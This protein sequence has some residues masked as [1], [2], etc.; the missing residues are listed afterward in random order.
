MLAVA[1]I[2]ILFVVKWPEVSRLFLILLFLAQA[3]AAIT[4]RALIRAYLYSARR[5]GRNMR[6]VLVSE[7]TR[8]LRRSRR[9]S[10]TTPSWAYGS[11][12]SSATKHASWLLAGPTSAHRRLPEVLHEFVI[13]EVIIGLPLAEW[14][15]IDAVLALCEQEGKIV[16]LRIPTPA[17]SIAR[18]RVEELDGT[19]IVSLGAGPIMGS[20]LAIKRAIDVVVSAVGS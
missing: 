20:G 1:T 14:S 19:M 12:G 16:R 10:P 3:I 8:A 11:R 5:R 7:P 15:G 9:R 13:D 18:G 2:S 17:L 4:F 6:H